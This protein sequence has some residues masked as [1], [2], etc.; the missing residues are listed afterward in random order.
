MG[1]RLMRHFGIPAEAGG[2]ISEFRSDQP[3]KAHPDYRAAKAGDP[4]AAARLVRDLVKPETLDAARDRFGPRAVYI[5][6]IALEQNGHN[7]IPFMLAHHFASSANARVAEDVMQV[8]RAHHTGARAMERVAVRAVF[9]GPVERD[10]RHVLV[11]DV[12][13][14]GSTLADLGNHVQAEGGIVIGAVTLANASRSGVLAAPKTLVRQIEARF[15]DAVREIFAI[16]PASLTADEATYIFNF[17]NAD[18]L[19]ARFAAALRERVER[20]RA[21]GIQADEDDGEMN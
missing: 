8:N 2:T 17:R 9:E 19:G 3:V 16:E 18:A 4:A 1:G 10:G 5:P 15:G 11:D 12:T 7:A 6:V 20:L 13:V 21:K 14:M